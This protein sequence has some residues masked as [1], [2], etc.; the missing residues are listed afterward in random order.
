MSRLLRLAAVI[1]VL[2]MAAKPGTALIPAREWMGPT[3]AGILPNSLP[4]LARNRTRDTES[5]G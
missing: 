4:C 3:L 5:P 1:A 2:G